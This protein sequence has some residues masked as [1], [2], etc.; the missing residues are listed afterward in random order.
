MP[1][2]FFKLANK[3]VVSQGSAG[4]LMTSYPLDLFFRY[5]TKKKVP[6]ISDLSSTASL[7]FRGSSEP[8]QAIDLL[9]SN[10]PERLGR[11]K[12]LGGLE[13]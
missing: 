4:L 13:V 3:S 10:G 6:L 2:C 7:L 11:L 1:Q 8:R 12:L 5:A 9:G